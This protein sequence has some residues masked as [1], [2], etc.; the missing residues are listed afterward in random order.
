M[1]VGSAELARASANY[2]VCLV[3]AVTFLVAIAYGS[4]VTT[5][6]FRGTAAAIVAKFVTP[7]LLRPAWS[8]VL[9]AMARDRAAVVPAEEPES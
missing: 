2:A 5:A 4:G 6:V 1:E 3:F 7:H 9:E 8:T